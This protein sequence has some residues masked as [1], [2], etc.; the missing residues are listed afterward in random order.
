MRPVGR[1]TVTTRNHSI[2]WVQY[3]IVDSCSCHLSLSC[4]SIRGPQLLRTTSR[5]AG[6]I[7]C[8]HT[9]SHLCRLFDCGSSQEML[10]PACVGRKAKRK[11]FLCG[12]TIRILLISSNRERPCT[13]PRRPKELTNHKQRW[14]MVLNVSFDTRRDTHLSEVRRG[15]PCLVAVGI[16]A[17]LIDGALRA[18]KP[19][20]CFLHWRRSKKS[21]ASC[22]V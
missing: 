18:G 8:A 12:E 5:S 22:H 6:P 9:H 15:S 16:G 10:K 2:C 11:P 20:R 21:T 3:C 4:L 7:F 1:S 19:P 14:Y 13:L 17:T